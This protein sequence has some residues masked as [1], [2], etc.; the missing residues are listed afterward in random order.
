M[1]FWKP[2]RESVMFFTS[3][4]CVECEKLQKPALN[5]LKTKS[6]QIYTIDAVENTKLVNYITG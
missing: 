5:E 2:G 3:N 4:S 6:T 1:P